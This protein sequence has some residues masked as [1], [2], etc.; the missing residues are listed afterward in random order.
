VAAAAAARAGAGL[1]SI[2]DL[3]KRISRLSGVA[4]ERADRLL[5]AVV[6]EGST[7]PPAT[8]EPWLR[9]TFGSVEA[10]RHQRLARV[11]NLATLES[12]VF[13]TLRSRR[14]VDG[15]EHPRDL[16]A[17]I[18][19]TAGDPFCDP[20]HQTPA[21]AFGR[22][23]GARMV[24]GANAALADAHHAVLVFDHHDPLALDAGLVQDLFDTGR[25]W[26]ERARE[27]DPA[28]DRYLLIWN[29]LWRAGGSI[30][31]GHA[32]ALLGRGRH[33]AALDRFLRDATAYR[34]AH[35]ADLVADLVD[36]H[37]DLGLA[38]DVA[39][40]VTV[41]A[42][43][44]PIKERELL[45]VGRPG[46]DE[47]EPAFA[48]ATWRALS[49]YHDRLGVRSFNLALW[50]SP[51]SVGENG[52]PPMVRIVDRGDPMRRPSDIGAMELYGTP[53]VGSDPYE[54]I[55]AFD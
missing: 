10:V 42:H 53:I 18:A 21:D 9:S 33:H 3:P 8:L 17:E 30:V 50:R 26:A 2:L 12:A 19:A 35:G 16:A 41:I 51:L 25:A 5:E 52:L 55:A 45:V 20:E 54:L 32:Q 49:A 40:G 11:T 46:M 31:H 43:L 15:G 29:C 6:I 22:V 36:L 24:T 14:P 48:D 28:A 1:T 38:R 27:T 34:E 4:R 13:A 7:V 47:R 37:R 44:T 23:R 39:E